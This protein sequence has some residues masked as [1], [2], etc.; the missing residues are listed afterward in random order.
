MSKLEKNILKIIVLIVA[1][2]VLSL[3]FSKKIYAQIPGTVED[4][5][6]GDNEYVPMWAEGGTYRLYC[7]NHGYSVHAGVTTYSAGEHMDIYDANAA[8]LIGMDPLVFAYIHLSGYT[9]RQKQNAIWLALGQGPEDADIATTIL[10]EATTKAENNRT[11]KQNVDNT[12]VPTDTGISF[13]GEAN[14]E[15]NPPKL[16]STTSSNNQIIYTIGKFS[17][18]YT[19]SQ[20]TK[21]SNMYIKAYDAN[22]NELK[23]ITINSFTYTDSNTKNQFV[24]NSSYPLPNKDFNVDFTVDG[25]SNVA[26][27]TLEIDYTFDYDINVTYD[28]IQGTI[29]VYYGSS[30]GYANTQ[31]LVGINV[32]N[33]PQSKNFNKHN[34]ISIS[35]KPTYVP[36]TMKLSGYVYRDEVSNT[37]T[38][39][40]NGVKDSN[41]IFLK[42]I[43]V[44]AYRKS[45]KEAVK[46]TKTDENGFYQFTDLPYLGTNNG[47]YICFTYNGL[48]YQHT[49][50]TTWS[51]SIVSKGNSALGAS[52]NVSMNNKIKNTDLTVN[53]SSLANQG[54]ILHDDG[55]GY[56]AIE[57]MK[58]PGVYLDV[59]NGDVAKKVWLY[60]T[61]D[62]SAQKWKLEDAGNG[63]YYIA[64]KID[65]SY[66]LTIKD[67]KLILTK[68]DSNNENNQ[69]FKVPKVTIGIKQEITSKSNAIIS[70]LSGDGVGQQ[71]QAITNSNNNDM[72]TIYNYDDGYYGLESMTSHGKF[73][74]IHNGQLDNEVWLYRFNGSAAQK[75]K[76]ENA[77]DGYY[78][79]ESALD[80]SY[81][82]TVSNGKLK[83][84][85]KNKNDA[86]QLFK[87]PSIVVSSNATETES[88]RDAFNNKFGTISADTDVNSSDTNL[89]PSDLGTNNKYA[90]NA[91]VGSNLNQ[92]ITYFTQTS[93][94][95]D[96]GL[97]AREQVDTSVSKDVYKTT[98]SIK[99]ISQDYIYNKKQGLST[100][101]NGNSYWG[102]SARASDAYYSNSYT[103]EV[104][105][106]DVYYSND[107]DTTKNISAKVTYKI[108]LQNHSTSIKTN[109]LELVDY[110]DNDYDKIVDAYTG[111]NAGKKIDD[112]YKTVTDK[113]LYKT[114]HTLS[115]YKT[116]Y[117]DFTNGISLEPGETKYVYV[118]LSASKANLL[119]NNDLGKGNIIEEMAYSTYYTDKSIA[120]NKDSKITYTE[121]KTGDTAGL[122]DINSNPGNVTKV[123]DGKTTYTLKGVTDGDG[124]SI[125]KTAPGA[126][127]TSDNMLEDDSDSAPYI[128]FTISAN[129]RT[130]S[131]VVWNDNRDTNEQGSEIGN[132]KDDK[133][134]GVGGVTV[135][136]W[137]KDTGNIAQVYDETQNKWVPVTTTSKDDGTYSLSGFAP[138]NYYI[139]FIYGNNK[140]DTTI[141]GQDY[142]STTYMNGISTG[143]DATNPDA[144]DTYPYS[145]VNGDTDDGTNYT[146]ANVSY[147]RDLNSI[148]QK[149]NAYCDNSGKDVTNG[150]ATTLSN[151]NSDDYVKNT[152]MEAKT[153]II[154]VNIEHNPNSTNS[155]ADRKYILSGINFG[156]VERPK[157]QLKLLK[158]V[159][160]VKVVTSDGVTLMDASQKQTNVMWIPTS[161]VG[162]KGYD[163]NNLMI[164]PTVRTDA[165]KKGKVQI[166]MDEELMHGASIKISYGIAVINIGEID[167]KD[168]AFYYK[169]TEANASTNLV[170]TRVNSIIDYVGY[171]GSTDSNVTRN[172]L[173]FD[174]NTNSNW[175]VLSADDYKN[176]VSSDVITNGSKYTTV[177]KY[178]FNKDL[179]P[180]LADTST[181]D[182]L[183]KLNQLTDGDDIENTLKNYINENSGAT[184]SDVAEAEAEPEE[185]VPLVG[186]TSTSESSSANKISITATSLVL[187]KGITPKDSTNDLTF[188]NMAEIVSTNNTV[189]RRMAYSVVG[190]QDPTKEPAEVD[191]DDAQEVTILPPFGQKYNYNI[192]Y[193]IAAGVAVILVAGIIII[194]KKV[195]KK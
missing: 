76:F 95:I 146:T 86:N 36:L 127:L 116:A 42:Y 148:R 122:I 66:Y 152:Q 112:I 39:A 173:A 188:D 32:T 117:I 14:W 147:A 167:Y 47:Y 157:A 184:S 29:A 128:K 93:T 163:T 73:L 79:I 106:A 75:W 194:K 38:G 191:A 118:T 186:S 67:N 6:R 170:T 159:T 108:T 8:S 11:N 88:D 40:L 155:S 65:T 169:G 59:L 1:I 189:G 62:T 34:K 23:N 12:T 18:N 131:G 174:G 87:I 103:R 50:Y 31:T 158:Q 83:V 130:A 177:I 26:Y 149:V 77:G 27:A 5:D 121:Y 129:S 24:A 100:D 124:K 82:L 126:P 160:N 64:S 70:S 187:T 113:S 180:V 13:N 46:T 91:Y 178:N 183:N 166:T 10:N 58:Y 16:I 133:E 171:N 92:E 20:Y 176:Y 145:V 136:L 153:G 4:G 51:Q 84:A 111:D 105:S 80:T 190:N 69:M 37:K 101:A 140:T 135:E 94:D 21:I 172:N 74:D 57:S 154:T 19:N 15:T 30:E 9:V 144:D 182:T 90:I 115:G 25:N 192:Y 45:T 110:Y 3:L 102:I 41:E 114:T 60:S 53:A 61:N 193:Y 151:K 134:N 104:Q 156:L 99:G 123:S 164:K 175:S 139:K 89:A 132:G 56:Y 119:D 98:L 179:I 2:I 107:A 137:D 125:T 22:K 63:Y 142:K 162:Y 43:M 49:K 150:L 181:A 72:F 168:S 165:S 33:N 138:G 78:Y 161:E 54:F 44:T 109:I 120:P 55:D 96:L 97:T 143:F 195:L 52:D 68:K 185:D 35:T 141:N 81:C 7:I 17:I 71:L 85:K 48:N 28:D